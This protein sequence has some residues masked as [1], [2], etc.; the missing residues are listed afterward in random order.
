MCGSGPWSTEYLGSTEG[1]RIFRRQK[2]ASAISSERLQIRPTL[3]YSSLLLSPLSP[4]YWLQNTWPWVTLNCYFALNSVLR[5][6]V[7]SVHM[8]LY[9]WNTRVFLYFYSSLSHRSQLRSDSCSLKKHLIWLIELK[10]D[11]WSSATL[12]LVVNVVGE[13]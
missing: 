6:C 4:F 3:L 5:R 1:L 2:V 7:W 8:E 11:F 10:P 9:T 12:K 13:L